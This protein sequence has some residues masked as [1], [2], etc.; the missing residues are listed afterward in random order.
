MHRY[1]LT[2]LTGT[3]CLATMV[4]AQDRFTEEDVINTLNGKPRMAAPGYAVGVALHVTFSPQAAAD[5]PAKRAMTGGNPQAD[6]TLYKALIP[7]ARALEA[8]MVRGSR[9]IVRLVPD[10][11]LPTEYANRL[12]QQLADTIE[13]FF[14]TYFAVPRGRLSLQTALPSSTAVGPGAPPQ[15]PQRWRLEVLRQE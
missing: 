5:T 1:F 9:Y 8:E 7:L 6:E 13:D 12:G 3:L 10:S 4:W 11:S 15:G 14:T 2:V